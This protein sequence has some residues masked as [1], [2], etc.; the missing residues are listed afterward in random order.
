[1][2]GF[3]VGAGDAPADGLL[4]PDE[5]GR[6]RLRLPRTPGEREH[7]GAPASVRPGEALVIEITGVQGRAAAD[8]PALEL[9]PPRM[10]GQTQFL[11]AIA[12]APAE[13]ASAP[14]EPATVPIFALNA[15]WQ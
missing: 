13:E 15:E 5:H 9:V 3:D 2:G 12:R 1:L 7:G 8:A 14:P 10:P 11:S 6:L 4:I